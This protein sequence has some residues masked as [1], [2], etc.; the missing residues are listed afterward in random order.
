MPQLSQGVVEKNEHGRFR[1]VEKDPTNTNAGVETSK[2]PTEAFL[3]STLLVETRNILEDVSV[4]KIFS[5]AKLHYHRPF[6]IFEI[7]CLIN[8]FPQEFKA[9]KKNAFLVESK[10]HG[11]CIAIIW[12]DENGSLYGA[13]YDASSNSVLTKKNKI[14]IR[15]IASE[16]QPLITSSNWQKEAM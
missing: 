11:L 1:F 16:I 6:L 14:A 7:I 15:Y 5:D 8:D 12:K 9:N 10:K 3:S 13:R 2:I 4:S